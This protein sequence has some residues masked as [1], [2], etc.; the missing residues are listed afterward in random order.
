LALLSLRRSFAPARAAFTLLEESKVVSS[1]PFMLINSTLNPG[2]LHF[3]MFNPRQVVRALI[4][5]ISLSLF[6]A[7]S[8]PFA[9]GQSFGLSIPLGL[10][11]PAV[12]PGGSSIAT[13]DLTSTGGF[14]SPV[15]LTCVLISGPVTTGTAAP[16]CTISP[17]SQTPPANG[18]SLTIT[19]SATT[20]VG[21]YNFTVTGTSG[22]ITQ[23]LNLTLQVQALTED[24]T[25]SVN[26]TTAV[27]SPLNAGAAAT[28]NVTISPIGNYTGQVTLACLSVTP[29]V[30]LAPVCIFTPPTINVTSGVNPTATLTLTTVGPVAERSNPR[31]F[32]ALWLTIPAFGLI[33]FRSSG[34]RR[35]TVLGALLL[36]LTLGNL[37]LIPSCSSN[38]PPGVGSVTPKNSYAFIL[39]GVDQNGNGP[40]NTTQATVSL[41]VK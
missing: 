12:D 39:T 37:L 19:T 27:P 24:Y 36:L 26:P 11:R 29:V 17:S 40:S 31:I 33:L 3:I 7:A 13:I 20:V 18:P 1:Q 38:R 5:A 8:A 25:L 41:T 16:V 15:A 32:Y 6:C 35:K 2:W 23:T 28:T 10:N 30:A 22:A 21:L 9:H 4:F 14:A 34:T